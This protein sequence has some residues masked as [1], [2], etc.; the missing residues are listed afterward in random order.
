MY[1][2]RGLTDLSKFK[3]ILTICYLKSIYPKR[4]IN[5]TFLI[6]NSAKITQKYEKKKNVFATMNTHL[7]SEGFQRLLAHSFVS[8]AMTFRPGEPA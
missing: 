8:G 6:T 5:E 3:A 2:K 7:Y 4:N 1:S